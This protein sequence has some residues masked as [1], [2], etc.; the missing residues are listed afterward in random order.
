MV[1]CGEKHLRDTGG[2]EEEKIMN[3][4]VQVYTGDGKGKTTAALGLAVRA[5]GAG[6]RV[7]IAQFVKTG[8]SGEVLA[9]QE[10]IPEIT[11]KQYGAD[12]FV[13]QPP[14][15]EDIA[16][17]REGLKNIRNIIQSG[18]YDLVI[19]DEANV[20]VHLGLFPV[21][22]LL[23]VIDTKPAEMEVV[24][25]GRNAHPRVIERADLVT[26]MRAVK[27]YYRDGVEARPGIER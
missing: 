11:L 25:T 22:E 23:E 27:H 10:R 21:E 9:M 16:C 15:P 6:L 4:L 13:T 12:D 7:C 24:I 14:K 17:A 20:A 3:G 1:F 26:E 2:T 5:F 8:G 18:E 19:L